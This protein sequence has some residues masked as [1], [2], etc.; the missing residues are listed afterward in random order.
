MATNGDFDYQGYLLFNGIFETEFLDQEFGGG[1]SEARARLG[2][3][4]PEYR[5]SDESSEEGYVRL[6]LEDA[7]SDDD[8][9]DSDLE[10]VAQSLIP[11]RYKYET[12]EPKDAYY[13]GEEVEVEVPYVQDSDLFWLYPNYM[14]LRGSKGD[15]KETKETTRRILDGHIRLNSVD[16]GGDFLLWLFY[17]EYEDQSL[18]TGI[19]LNNLTDT[20]LTGDRD[21]FGGATKVDDSTDLERCVPMLA[22]ILKDKTISTMQGYFRLFDEYNLKAQI[23]EGRVHIKASRGDIKTSGDVRRMA[24]SIAFLHELIDLHRS[25]TELP[26]TSRYPP[27]QFFEDLHDTANEQGVEIQSISTNVLTKYASK[28]GEDP[29]S[30][31]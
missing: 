9:V 25:W 31:T 22:G 14:F 23:G 6:L 30:W 12:R 21:A 2:D 29:D 27:R 7:I 10:E 26:P 11:Y 16:F 13:R 8:S 3:H 19:E 18:P 20:E 1:R 15:V 17:K 4:L 28:R 24:I 5:S